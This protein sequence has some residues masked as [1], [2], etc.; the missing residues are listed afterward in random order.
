MDGIEREYGDNLLVLRVNIQEPLG[1]ELQEI[2][3]VEFTPTFLL[4]NAEGEQIGT[5]VGAIDPAIVRTAV[6]S[7]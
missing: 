1:E 7:Q 3:K 4:F 6:E 2:Y 5:Y